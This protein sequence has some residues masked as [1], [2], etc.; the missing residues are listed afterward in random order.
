MRYVASIGFLGYTRCNNVCAYNPESRGFDDLT[1]AEARRLIDSG[2]LKGLFWKNGSDGPEFYPDVNGFNQ[3]DVMIKSA[4]KFRPMI[5]DVVGAVVNSFFTLVRVLDTD[6][7]GRL[8]EVVS[9]KYSRM[10]L[11]EQSLRELADITLISGL[12]ITDEGIKIADGVQYE[13]RRLNKE[14]GIGAGLFKDNVPM[15][16]DKVT[17]QLECPEQSHEV[18]ESLKEQQG[19]EVSA[20]DRIFGTESF[21]NEAETLGQSAMESLFDTVDEEKETVGKEEKP[22]KDKKSTN[23]KKE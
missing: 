20:L 18:K 14:F 16:V 2:Q 6:Y 7:K 13:D 9:N 3:T 21:V 8:Y 5:K 4:N 17:E 1:P 23:K 15:R 10:K 22:V 19:Q 11:V 12:W